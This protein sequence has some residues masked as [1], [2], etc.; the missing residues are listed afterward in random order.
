MI[1][2]PGSILKA[3]REKQNKSLEEIAH[4]LKLSPDYLQAIEEGSYGSIPA[5]IFVK[6]YI[7]FYA[8]A[9]GL[10][11]D[12]ILDLYHKKETGPPVVRPATGEDEEI[13]SY[14][15]L[16]VMTALLAIFTAT[17]LFMKAPVPLE[18]RIIP[19]AAVDSHNNGVSVKETI[20]KEL[21]QDVVPPAQDVVL[22]AQDVV[23][24]AKD[25]VPSVQDVVPPAQDVVLPAQ[26]VV[27]PAKDVVSPVQDVMPPVQDAV[28]PSKRGGSE[29]LSL[30]IEATELTWASVSI[31]GGE[32]KEWQL[33]AGES[34]EFQAMEIFRI[35]VGNA[36]GTKLYF[37][38]SY[39]GELGD[40]G[41][42]VDIVLPDNS[43][44]HDLR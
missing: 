18:K 25:V 23:S 41:K 17:A 32:R 26:D 43:N 34:K 21:P 20:D 8:D 31:D 1:N 11:S 5:E 42:I 14:R 6:A 4:R 19:P 13:F 28:S 40:H 12:F 33:R 29:K 36:G 22:P 9:L 44:N 10:D 39:L 27:S 35:K 3:E 38:G 2:T 15:P 7:R 24:P 37:N 16:A 30:R